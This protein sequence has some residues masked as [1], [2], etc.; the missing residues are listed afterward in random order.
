[1][2]IM[3][4]ASVGSPYTSTPQALCGE[5]TPPKSLRYSMS[6]PYHSLAAI[7]APPM[8]VPNPPRPLVRLSTTRSAPRRKGFWQK[9]VANVLSTITSTRSFSSRPALTLSA[10]RRMAAMSINSS[11]GLI[12][13]SK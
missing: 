13:V 9:G 11:V 6:E 12:G 3:R 2:L 4:V 10:T 1:M 5:S 8:S 7:T